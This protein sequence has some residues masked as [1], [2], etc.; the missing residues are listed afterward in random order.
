MKLGTDLQFSF[1][2]K[3]IQKHKHLTKQEMTV[4]TYFTESCKV[5][6]KSFHC[7]HTTGRK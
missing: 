2:S 1:D 5:T 3:Q 6:E 4:F 7:C